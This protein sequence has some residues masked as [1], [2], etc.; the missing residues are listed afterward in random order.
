MLTAVVLVCIAGTANPESCLTY[1]NKILY[2]SYDECKA[3]VFYA[4]ANN[5]FNMYDETNN[6]TLE[7][8]DWY[9]IN[10]DAENV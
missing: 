3:S 8:R 1:T 7:L 6:V 2:Q 4:L 10:W 9:C 5:Y